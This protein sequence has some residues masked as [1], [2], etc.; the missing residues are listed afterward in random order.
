MSGMAHWVGAANRPW[1]GSAWGMFGYFVMQAP[2]I[3]V[4]DWVVDWGRERGVSG[5]RKLSVCLKR[6]GK[7]ERCLELTV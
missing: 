7:R 3:R 5:T 1:T 6:F 4:E 2:V